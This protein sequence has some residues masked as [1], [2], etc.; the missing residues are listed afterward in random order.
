MLSPSIARLQHFTLPA[1]HWALNQA[2]S[3]GRRPSHLSHRPMWAFTVAHRLILSTL[4]IERT[5][6]APK[7]LERKLE[8]A[9]RDGQLPSVVIVVHL[10][11][12]PCEMDQMLTLKRK[13]GFHIIEDASHALGA[14]FQETRI[15]CCAHSDIAVFSF[16]PVKIITTAEGG[17]ATTNCPDLAQKNAVIANSRHH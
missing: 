15:G 11:G 8:Q 9:K 17:A 1:L 14:T 4:T 13:Y 5:T 3:F 12:Q 6:S 10:A 16:H 7:K 2:T